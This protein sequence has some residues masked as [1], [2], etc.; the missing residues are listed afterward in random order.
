MNSPSSEILDMY[1]F[2]VQ[3]SHSTLFLT[4]IQVFKFI[5]FCPLIITVQAKI[6]GNFFNLMI[7]SV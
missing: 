4:H 7:L 1:F 3:G 2:H 6:Y 5:F